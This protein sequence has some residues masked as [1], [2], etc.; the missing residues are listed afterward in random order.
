MIAKRKQQR[1]FGR[2][3][4][5]LFFGIVGEKKKGGGKND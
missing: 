4:F 1:F 2:Q 3:D 5:L